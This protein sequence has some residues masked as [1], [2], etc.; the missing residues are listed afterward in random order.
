M[1]ADMDEMLTFV[2][3]ISRLKPVSFD[4]ASDEDLY[5]NTEALNRL[6]DTARKMTSGAV[7]TLSQRELAT[8]LASLRTFQRLDSD[9]TIEENL[10]ATEN[11]EI[12]ALTIDEIDGLCDRLNQN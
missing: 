3:M 9:D 6:I 8:V 5:S 7:V 2:K 1:P 11:G 12:D 10:I 4:D